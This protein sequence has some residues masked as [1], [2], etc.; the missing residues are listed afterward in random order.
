MVYDIVGRNPR[1]R[2]PFRPG[3]EASGVVVECGSEVKIFQKGD[4]V[5]F[6]GGPEFADYVIVSEQNTVQLLNKVSFEEGLGEPL[7]SALYGALGSGVKVG[8]LC[9]VLGAGYFG[10]L[11]MQGL[12]VLGAD[13]VVVADLYDGRLDKAL[14]LGADRVVNP[15]REELKR[16][17]DEE[18][19]G[20]GMDLV[21]E[22]TGSSDV[23]NRASNYLKPEGILSIFSYIVDEVQL[24]HISWHAKALTIHNTR[25][26]TK[27]LQ[28]IRKYMK[29][30]LRWTE[31][32]V[33][34]VKPLITD[35]LRLDQLIEEVRRTQEQPNKTLKVVITPK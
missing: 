6:L 13:K 26:I 4:R 12:K 10:Q 21:I 22:A 23:L 14:K 7:C 28:E 17:V 34:H 30:A 11:I 25:C 24:D 18:S 15:R 33:W 19:G 8:D 29:L 32:G 3:H 1:A 31:M 20:R 16:V 2:F 5:T 35:I 9:L 27:P